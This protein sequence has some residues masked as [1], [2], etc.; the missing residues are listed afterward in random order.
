MRILLTCFE[1]FGPWQ[2]NASALAVHEAVARYSGPSTIEVRE[3]A[4]DFSTIEQQLLDDLKTGP[5]LILHTGQ[6]SEASTIELESVALNLRRDS[7]DDLCSFPLRTDGPLAY[8]SDLPLDEWCGVLREHGLSVSVSHH[9]GTYLCNAVLFHAL[10][11]HFVAAGPPCLFVHLPLTPDQVPGPKPGG[12]PMKT[13][14]AAEGLL[15]ILTMC[16]E[17]SGLTI[18]HRK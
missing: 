11:H 3:Y 12:S 10:H 5:D 13:A 18:G 7:E 6:S 16:Q 2:E 14:A 4:V 1:P 8:Q 17:R 9:A 15:R